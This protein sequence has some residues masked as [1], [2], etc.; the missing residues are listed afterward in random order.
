MGHSTVSTA[1]RG[2][3]PWIP[4]W[5]ETPRGRLLDIGPSS[6]LFGLV[7]IF[8]SCHRP[9]HHPTGESLIVRPLYAPRKQ[10]TPLA[11]GRLDVLAWC[12]LEGLGVRHEV[13]CAL[14]VLEANVP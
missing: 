9:K 1:P 8:P 6:I 3:F 7:P 13:V 5:L 12:L 10:E 2:R 4:R 11:D 14:S